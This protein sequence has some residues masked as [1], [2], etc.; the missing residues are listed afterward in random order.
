MSD[1]VFWFTVIAMAIAIIIAIVCAIVLPGNHEFGTAIC[2]ETEVYST[3]KTFIREYFLVDENH[4][5][6]EINDEIY[7]A[8]ALP[9]C[10][11]TSD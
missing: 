9:D 4:H 10:S 11:N 3:G 8:L 2:K 1:R 7:R 6:M 5:K